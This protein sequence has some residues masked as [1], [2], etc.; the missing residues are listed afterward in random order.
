M[1]DLNTIAFSLITSEYFTWD[2]ES[3]IGERIETVI[4]DWDNPEIGFDLTIDNIKLWKEYLLTGDY[5]LDEESLK[6]KK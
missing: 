5:K 1:I 6:R 4:Y 3:K 2:S